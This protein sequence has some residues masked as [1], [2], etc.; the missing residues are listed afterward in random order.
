MVPRGEANKVY[1]GGAENNNANMI[2]GDLSCPD[3]CV[4]FKRVDCK[5]SAKKGVCA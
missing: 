2:Q 3:H 5:F 1:V 4:K